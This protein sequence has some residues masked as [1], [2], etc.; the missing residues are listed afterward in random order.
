M[1]GVI[2]QSGMILMLFYATFNMFNVLYLRAPVEFIGYVLLAISSLYFLQRL[3][4]VATRGFH[5]SQSELLGY[6]LM[7]LILAT[8]TAQKIFLG[9]YVGFDGI[10][11]LS[12]IST[13]Y[14]LM[15]I[16]FFAGG[17]A[18]HAVFGES[19]ATALIIMIILVVSIQLGLGDEA[20]VDYRA[21]N[22][23]SGLE[24]ISHLS[25]EKYILLLLAFAYAI[26]SKTRWL[27]LLIGLF[28][29]FL[30]GGRTALATFAV[31]GLALSLRGN[32]TRNLIL[33]SVV[34]VIAFSFL[35]YTIDTGV[36]DVQSKAV[37][38]ILFLD[39]FGE[40][41]SFNARV[42]LYNVA[43]PHLQEQFL[44]GD[45]TLTT[46]AT[47][48]FGTYIHN[49]LSAWQFFGFFVFLGIAL[50]LLYCLHR[51]MTALKRNP[52][53]IDVFGAFMVIYVIIS[54]IVGKS[55]VYNLLWFVLGF[56]LLKPV[57]QLGKSGARR[58]RR[59]RR[60]RT[61]EQASD[62]PPRPRSRGAVTS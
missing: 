36:I 27:A 31:T 56:W 1:D 58:M 61:G 52:T 19:M 47:G 21:I 7:L 6:F 28:V 20:A 4:R 14:L 43:L 8:I 33:F 49:L 9:T 13:V 2:R 45:Y 23:E 22:Q 32:M 62:A 39:G 35:R 53:T 16:W 42:E 5:L 26:C 24:D 54:M 25:L 30:M 40:D 12:N 50:A 46:R 48:Y 37:R 38:D 17:A 60:S 15:V 34:S 10:D 18:A 11:T 41:A 55:V 44:F 29:L 51:A 57:M 3:A 59:R